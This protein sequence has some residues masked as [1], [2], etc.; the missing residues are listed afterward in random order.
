MEYS[1]TVVG[2]LTHEERAPALPHP[3][4]IS[5]RVLYVGAADGGTWLNEV[6]SAAGRIPANVSSGRQRAGFRFERSVVLAYRNELQQ[7]AAPNGEPGERGVQM[8]LAR[9]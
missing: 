2:R 5:H 1:L 9:G 4:G 8:A 7:G 6:L 3:I